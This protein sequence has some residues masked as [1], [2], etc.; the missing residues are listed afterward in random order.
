MPQSWASWSSNGSNEI[1]PN[2]NR[3][4]ICVKL[5]VEREFVLAYPGTSEQAIV[6]VQNVPVSLAHVSFIR[7]LRLEGA[8][9]FADL[10]IDAPIIGEQNLDFHSR[11]ETTDDGA[12]L[13]ALER[14]GKAW[15]EVAGQ[16]HVTADTGHADGANSSIRYLLRIVVHLELPVTDRWG[17]RAF[18]KMA[19]A[20]AQRSIE[21]LSLEFPEGVLAAMRSPNPQV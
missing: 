8:D 13:I 6:F 15:A 20:T 1:R 7:N 3:S 16:A 2:E 18:E 10:R 14:T 19:Q 5:E 11:L 21:R 4:G 17:G 12:R 9:I